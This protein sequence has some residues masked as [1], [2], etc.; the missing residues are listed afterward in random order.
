MFYVISSLIFKLNYSV[1]KLF[2]GFAMAAFIVCRQ[3]II[4]AIISMQ[5]PLIKNIHQLNGILNAKSCSQLFEKYHATGMAIIEAININLAK[6][7]ESNTMICITDAPNT[8]LMP[9]SFVL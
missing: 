5:M 8:F 9:I 6:F 4:N 3:R 1:L 2:T 7:F